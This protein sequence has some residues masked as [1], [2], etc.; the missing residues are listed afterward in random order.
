[1]SEEKTMIQLQAATV[2]VLHRIA[3][4]LEA[5]AL[6]KA[7]APNF[8]RPIGEYAEFDFDAIGAK[9][10]ARDQHGPTMLEWGGYQWTR[11][12]PS[13]KFGSAIWFSRPIGKDETGVRYARLI[14]FREPGEAEPLPGKVAEKVG[15]G[16]PAAAH[17][18]AQAHP[19][20]EAQAHAPID[21]DVAQAKA[22]PQTT[23]ATGDKGHKYAHVKSI[24]WF[25]RAKALAARA[26]YYQ[27]KNGQPN[28]YH[29]A[30]AALKCGYQE[31]TDENLD[32]VLRDLEQHAIEQTTEVT[33]G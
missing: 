15:N 1:M 25:E 9:V 3:T 17:R 12:S 11:R 33:H 19:D 18:P 21:A 16:K 30:G 24:A 23:P 28:L 13:N 8:V 7:P 22:K 29:L 6:T 10:A 20:E 5:I 32:A 31:I 14:T 26:P 4:A 27:D 2:A